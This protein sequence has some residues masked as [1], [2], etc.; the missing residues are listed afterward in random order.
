MNR[1]NRRHNRQKTG[2]RQAGRADT[3]ANLPEWE[4]LD[5]EPAWDITL[6]AWEIEL[7][8]IEKLP[9]WLDNPELLK[10]P[11]PPDFLEPL[12]WKDIELPDFGENTNRR[13]RKRGTRGKR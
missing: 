6:P 11:E 5:F 1:I 3:W 13:G 12:E 7:P 2:T 4:D 8:D 9:E 10:L